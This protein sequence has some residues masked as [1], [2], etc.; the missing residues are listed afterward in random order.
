VK[1]KG[2]EERKGSTVQAVFLAS[3]I[4]FLVFFFFSWCLANDGK[5]QS[6]EQN[7]AAANQGCKAFN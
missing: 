7:W 6:L 2:K 5:H 1:G 3:I 4:S